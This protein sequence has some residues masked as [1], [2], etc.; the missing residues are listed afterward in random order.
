MKLHHAHHTITTRCTHGCANTLYPMRR[1]RMARTTKDLCWIYAMR[2]TYP[3]PIM[4]APTWGG[5]LA[6][7]PLGGHE[8]IGP[9]PFTRG[10]H[11]TP[12][13]A[14]ANT[15]CLF[16]YSTNLSTRQPIRRTAGGISHGS[17]PASS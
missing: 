1:M 14:G 7:P 6:I 17:P 16:P 9:G 2:D 4:G 11:A 12:S 8:P 5:P 10:A 15:N 3:R 13:R